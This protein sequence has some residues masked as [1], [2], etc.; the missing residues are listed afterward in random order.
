MDLI[1]LSRRNGGLEQSHDRAMTLVQH[2]QLLRSPAWPT[3]RDGDHV[4]IC[5]SRSVTWKVS[6]TGQVL[7]PSTFSQIC[8]Q[9]VAQVG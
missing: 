2:G 4:G 3:G 6:I 7:H 8:R 1:S 9:T 5:L